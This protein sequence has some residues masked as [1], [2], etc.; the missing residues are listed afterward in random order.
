[1]VQLT[2]L[3]T[4]NQE[5]D[6][7][8]HSSDD[9]DSEKNEQELSTPSIDAIQPTQVSEPAPDASAI[10]KQEYVSGLK[11][12]PI[13]TAIT[14]AFFLMLLD[15]SIIVTA[16]PVITNHFHS[17]PDV[18]WYGAAYQLSWHAISISFSG[19]LANVAL[20]LCF[21]R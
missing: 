14:L 2:E 4:E 10:I 8:R 19:S 5:Q 11:L 18:G 15:T 3:G 21:N 13:M 6:P 9:L 12:L 1:M 16:I 17:L 20:V 7:S